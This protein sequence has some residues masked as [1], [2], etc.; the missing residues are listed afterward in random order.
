MGRA[1]QQSLRRLCANSG[2][3]PASKLTRCNRQYALWQT[4]TAAR[5]APRTGPPVASFKHGLDKL[6]PCIE[7]QANIKEPQ[8]GIDFFS[9]F[10]LVLNGLDNLDARRH[11]NRLCLAANVPLVESGTAGYLGQVTAPVL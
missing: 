8:F 5:I 7:P 6:S 2:Q 11:V 4:T 1:R 10:T 3:M 9:K